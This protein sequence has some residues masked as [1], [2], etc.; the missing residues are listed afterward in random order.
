MRASELTRLQ[1]YFRDLF[2]DELRVDDGWS[3]YIDLLVR[4]LALGSYSYLQTGGVPYLFRLG[5]FGALTGNVRSGSV[6]SS[7]DASGVVSA[8]PFCPIMDVGDFYVLCFNL[9]VSSADSVWFD[10]GTAD[11]TPIRLV[12]TE[13]EVV[14][15]ESAGSGSCVSYF[16]TASFYVPATSQEALSFVQGDSLHLPSGISSWSALAWS[17][18]ADLLRDITFFV[19][20]PKVV[21]VSVGEPLLVWDG[22]GEST[23]LT[24]YEIAGFQLDSIP[25]QLNGSFILQA[26]QAQGSGDSLYGV[27]ATQAGIFETVRGFALDFERTPYRL[28]LASG[29]DMGQTER[30]YDRFVEF[31]QQLDGDQPLEEGWPVV[32]WD[33]PSYPELLGLVAAERTLVSTVFDSW[34]KDESSESGLHT[35]VSSSSLNP[36]LR[37]MYRKYGRGIIGYDK[38]FWVVV[39]N[40]LLQQVYGLGSTYKPSGV[41]RVLEGSVEDGQL[42]VQFAPS[43]RS[44]DAL[45]SPLPSFRLDAEEDTQDIKFRTLAD[46]ELLPEPVG[47][48]PESAKLIVESDYRA[49]NDAGGFVIGTPVPRG[50]GNSSELL[51]VEESHPIQ[52]YES[53]TKDYHT[54]SVQSG[55]TDVVLV[56]FACRKDDFARMLLDGGFISDLSEVDAYIAWMESV[57]R[58]SVPVGIDLQVVFNPPPTELGVAIGAQEDGLLDAG[59]F[60]LLVD[61]LEYF[62]KAGVK[63]DL[64]YA[65]AVRSNVEWRVS[66]QGISDF[67]LV[68]TIGA[69]AWAEE[70]TID[71]D[72]IS[73]EFEMWSSEA[74]TVELR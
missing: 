53:I 36:A 43:G 37:A 6:T 40:S 5:D 74:F 10:F 58:R 72:G 12:G 1:R 8:I 46:G 25:M 38:G 11:G 3:E 4:N 26:R 9:P 42:L 39:N 2:I 32:S 51:L 64:F 34:G 27:S 7:T 29:V 61:P 23:V 18:Y 60:H 31:R 35:L 15:E 33:Y 67:V 45:D 17:S 50:S 59:S 44:A 49:Y 13:Q 63:H 55:A 56:S 14:Y 30:V 21:E 28:Y 54:L 16:P 48:I 70:I 68:R 24:D 71:F 41:I 20:I 19:R 47:G 69:V 52:T 73:V 22:S 57:L 62:I 66:T 65:I